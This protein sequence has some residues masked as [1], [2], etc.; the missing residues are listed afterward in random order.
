MNAKDNKRSIIVGLFVF[1]GMA[2]LIAGI[3]VLG[4][5]QKR[6]GGIVHVHAIFDNVGGL[7]KG[8]NIWFSGVKVGTI[9]E[10]HFTKNR[11]VEIVMGI[12]E[13]SQEYI[14]KD[15]I[16]QIGSEGIIGNKIIVIQG[17]SSKVPFIEEGDQLESKEANDTDAMMATLQVNNENLVAIT[18]DIKKLS[19][20]VLRG[21]GTV[22]AIFTDSLMAENIKLL[23][24]NLNQTALNSRKIS[25]NFSRFSEKLNNEGSLVNELLTDTVVFDNLESAVA[26]LQGITQA[27]AALT[28]N[29]NQA[30]SNLNEKDNP[31]GMFLNDPEMASQLKRTMNN[32]ESSTEKLDENMEALQHNFLL[33]GFFRKQAKKEAKAAK[34][35][36]KIE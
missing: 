26:Q 15:A 7:K 30:S 24:R 17:G 19:Q 12:E 29:L 36:L 22:G 25:E 9:R 21:E 3:L 31:A 33:R 6:F 34:D 5:Q 14:R 23:I 27:A 35:S 32:L 8:S 2:I 11:Q 4:G 16:A 28:E 10:I 20:K 1:L 18:A 13:K